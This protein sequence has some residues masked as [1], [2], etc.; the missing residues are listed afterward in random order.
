MGQVYV[1]QKAP[2]ALRAAAQGLM[3]FLTYGIGMFVGSL[4]CGRIVDLYSRSYP[5]GGVL[6]DWRSIWMVPAIASAIVLIFF[7]SGFRNEESAVV[8]TANAPG[9]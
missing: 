4:I 5:S 8:I 2:S 1:D 9:S 7:W 6:H 3:T